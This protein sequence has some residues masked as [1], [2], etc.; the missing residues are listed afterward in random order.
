MK[1]KSPCGRRGLRRAS[2]AAAVIDSTSTIKLFDI[3]KGAGNEET[4]F[5]RQQGN[6]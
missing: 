4:K 1:N 2:I 5:S 6:F 3:F